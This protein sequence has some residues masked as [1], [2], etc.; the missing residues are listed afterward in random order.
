MIL[1]VPKPSKLHIQAV[2]SVVTK[3]QKL[4]GGSVQRQHTQRAHAA[5]PQ[6]AVAALLMKTIKGKNRQYN[7]SQQQGET[8]YFLMNVFSYV[9]RHSFILISWAILSTL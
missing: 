4:Q 1:G 7:K 6:L 8:H 3:G 9:S 5:G 2:T